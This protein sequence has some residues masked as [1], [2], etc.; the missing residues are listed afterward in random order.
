MK[1]ILIIDADQNYGRL[2]T[3]NLR[4][5]GYAVMQAGNLDEAKMLLAD[6]G[7]FVIASALLL[8]DENGF[9]V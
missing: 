7:P 4:R 5:E 2:L 8:P 1:P 6:S 3:Q 9:E